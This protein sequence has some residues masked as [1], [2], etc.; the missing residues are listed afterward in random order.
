MISGKN[1]STIERRFCQ[2]KIISDKT[3]A[4]TEQRLQ[5][6]IIARKVFAGTDLLACGRQVSLQAKDVIAAERSPQQNDFFKNAHRSRRDLYRR[7][8]C[9]NWAALSQQKGN[10]NK[11]LCRKSS[12]V[13]ERR[14]RGRKFCLNLLALSRQNIALIEMLWRISKI[15]AVGERRY[16]CR[17]LLPRLKNII[18][19]KRLQRSSALS[20]RNHRGYRRVSAL[21]DPSPTASE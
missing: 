3:I 12:T 19:F 5:K 10:F 11:R 20:W 8:S 18:S 6:R 9:R 17:K 14:D 21:G 4:A 13:G 15:F 2:T 1:I 7:N 16:L